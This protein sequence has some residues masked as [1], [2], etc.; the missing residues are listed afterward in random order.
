[1]V[2]A[3]EVAVEVDVAVAVL[4]AVA[5]A[6]AVWV[7]V[8]VAVLVGVR[9]DVLVG[10]LVGVDVGVPEPTSVEPDGFHVLSGTEQPVLVVLSL[11][12]GQDPLEKRMSSA[13]TL[14]SI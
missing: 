9:V 6:V 13:V 5:V 11:A 4:V 12:G 2:V 1:I 14:M 8:L 3:V 10:L 7:G